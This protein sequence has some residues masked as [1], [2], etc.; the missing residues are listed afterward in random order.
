L[1]SDVDEV[2]LI[3]HIFIK[4]LAPWFSAKTPAHD[5]DDDT[6]PITDPE[7]L[8]KVLVKLFQVH[9]SL[10]KGSVE[11]M[12]L[13]GLRSRKR[14]ERHTSLDRIFEFFKHSKSKELKYLWDGLKSQ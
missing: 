11:G 10:L 7:S 3:S 2:P 14:M 1:D 6:A 9:P 5:P 12:M 8:M 13:N 4:V